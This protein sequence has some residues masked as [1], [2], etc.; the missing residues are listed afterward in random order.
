MRRARIVLREQEYDRRGR[1]WRKMIKVGGKAAASTAR[2]FCTTCGEQAAPGGVA[3]IVRHDHQDASSL[4]YPADGSAS[5]RRPI[6]RSCGLHPQHLFLLAAKTVFNRNPTRLLRRTLRAREGR[7]VV[8]VDCAFAQARPRARW[9]WRCEVRDRECSDGCR[10]DI[11]LVFLYVG[12]G[13]A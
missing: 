1:T 4:L 10:A 8:E 7:V 9:T 5:R 6:S 12:C 13:V 3:S 2:V 11:L